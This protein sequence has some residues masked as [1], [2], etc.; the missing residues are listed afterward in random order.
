MFRGLSEE[1]NE[2]DFDSLLS[3]ENAEAARVLYDFKVRMEE[4]GITTTSKKMDE[5]PQECA[6]QHEP[7]SSY[8]ATNSFSNVIINDKS[9]FSNLQ[10]KKPK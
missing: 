10:F 7:K 1:L 4:L 6:D 9:Y 8:L 3:S 5:L 2:L